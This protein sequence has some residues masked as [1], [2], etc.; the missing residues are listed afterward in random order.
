MPQ[1]THKAAEKQSDRL[2]G[3]KKKRKRSRRG[4]SRGLCL[5][6]FMH[7]AP[8]P[9]IGRERDTYSWQRYLSCTSSPVTL[10]IR[11]IF[12][13]T[14]HASPLSPPP[15]L[16][17]FCTSCGPKDYICFQ[18]LIGS[19]YLSRER[20]SV[21]KMSHSSHGGPAG[22]S[23]LARPQIHILTACYGRDAVGRSWGLPDAHPYTQ[24]CMYMRTL[25]PVYV[26]KRRQATDATISLLSYN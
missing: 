20:S 26:I 1:E 11:P 19:V 16:P 2:K 6:L 4:K 14:L 23:P 17:S 13:F 15:P 22:A 3:R 8:P 25:H 9:K 12:P 24:T 18:F 10:H 5:C 21:R 7:G